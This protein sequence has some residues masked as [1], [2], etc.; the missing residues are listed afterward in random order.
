MDILD[1]FFCF[2]DGN[3]VAPQD[4]REKTIDSLQFEFA[5]L[6]PEPGDVGDGELLLTVLFGGGG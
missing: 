5:S 2:I 6:G 3:P 1:V 4:Y